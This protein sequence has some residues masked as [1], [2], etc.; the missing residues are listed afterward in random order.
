MVRQSWASVGF[1]TVV[2]T[3]AAFTGHT[4]DWNDWSNVHQC[5]K[6]GKS[7]LKSRIVCW[8]DSSNVRFPRNAVWPLKLRKQRFDPVTRNEG[9]NVNCPQLA[10][11]TCLLAQWSHLLCSSQFPV[12]PGFSECRTRPCPHSYERKETSLSFHHFQFCLAYATHIHWY[13]VAKE[14]AWED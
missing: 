5:W 4:A 2:Q 9:G 6:S 10:G 1:H 7:S 12:L 3:E 8:D 13:N 14:S 11:Q